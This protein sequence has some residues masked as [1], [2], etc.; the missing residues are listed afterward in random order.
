MD[1]AEKISTK[2]ICDYLELT[3]WKRVKD[4]IAPRALYVQPP[5][6]HVILVPFDRT[7][8]DYLRRIQ[9]VIVSLSWIE[10]R[11]IGDVLREF[12]PDPFPGH[13]LKTIR[14][15]F[16]MVVM[17]LRSLPDAKPEM[18]EHTAKFLEQ[19][20]KLEEGD[21]SVP[22]QA[23][24]SLQNAC[25]DALQWLQNF[26][27]WEAIKRLAKSSAR[28]EVID[29]AEARLGRA[30]KALDDATDGMAWRTGP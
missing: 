6:Q 20:R 24:Q 22:W 15:N 25:L 19:L 17:H 2:G 26:E 11:P 16:E 29:E 23:P 18:I 28:Q 13:M 4:D 8:A 27:D 5:L 7:Y 10:K 30:I 14:F 3:G 1:R 12:L 21:T 9:Q